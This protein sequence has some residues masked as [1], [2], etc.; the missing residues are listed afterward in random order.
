MKAIFNKS[1]D[2]ESKQ[3]ED[4]VINDNVEFDG[5]CDARSV[6]GPLMPELYS[7]H[8]E[9]MNVM[10]CSDKKLKKKEE[11]KRNFAFMTRNIINR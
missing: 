6:V 9:T 4:T 2:K 7:Q 8:S 1:Q 3:E 11:N 10:M 5:F